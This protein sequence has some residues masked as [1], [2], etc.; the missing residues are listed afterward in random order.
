VWT[1]RGAFGV[2]FFPTVI[3]G[4]ATVKQTGDRSWE[5]AGL[6]AEPV[7]IGSN[8]V[9]YFM[10]HRNLLLNTDDEKLYTA[11]KRALRIKP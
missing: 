11:L 3:E 5:I 9:R 10:L 8:R 2:T 7:P 6:T 4:R 1:A